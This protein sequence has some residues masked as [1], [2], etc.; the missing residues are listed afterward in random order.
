M[1]VAAEGGEWS[2]VR[3]GRT[4]PPG[5]TRYPFYRRLG[6][7][8]GRSGRAENLVP[9]GIRSYTIQPVVS[10]YT[11]WATRPTYQ[12]GTKSKVQDATSSVQDTRGKQV[13]STRCQFFNTRYKGLPSQQY[14]T[15]VRQYKTARD[16]KLTGQD[17]SSS[18]TDT[19]GHQASSTRHWNSVHNYVNTAWELATPMPTMSV[20]PATN[21][22]NSKG[23]RSTVSPSLLIC[24][25]LSSAFCYIRNI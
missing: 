9:T 6:G 14:K 3:P 2:A 7:P 17:A 8:Q 13:N 5:K 23:T 21:V 19:R 15:P 4:L 10:R 11:D 24:C 16:T 12:E 20:Y 22:K 1:S 25:K 18:V